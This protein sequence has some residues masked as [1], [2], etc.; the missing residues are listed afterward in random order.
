M[1]QTIAVASVSSVDSAG[2]PT[3]GTA[4][5]VL[6]RFETDTSMGDSSDGTQ[7]STAHTFTTATAITDTD[8]IWI[9]ADVVTPLSG[10]DAKKAR[11]PSRVQHVVDDDGTT[12]AYLVTL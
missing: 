10:L 3:Y 12:I 5:S 6:C 9:P 2:K 4:T 8:R 1:T 11:N 7:R